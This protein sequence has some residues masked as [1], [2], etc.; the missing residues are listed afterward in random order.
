MPLHRNHELSFDLYMSRNIK[1]LMIASV[2]NLS[3]SILTTFI[4]NKNSN[5]Y[6]FLLI[7]LCSNIF[8]INL[9]FLLILN[10]YVALRGQHLGNKELD[11]RFLYSDYKYDLGARCRRL[12]LKDIDLATKLA[13]GDD[14]DI[15]K[16]NQYQ[17]REDIEAE[18]SPILNQIARKHMA[19][20]DELAVLHSGGV[21]GLLSRTIS[22]IIP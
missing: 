20:E 3:S 15:Q 18:I 12:E 2:V 1:F 17:T 8:S 4:I 7:K 10:T 13:S 9:L 14:V 22:R 19:I 6:L 5:P 11:L 16:Y 21:T